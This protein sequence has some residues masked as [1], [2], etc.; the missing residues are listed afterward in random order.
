MN[1]HSTKTLERLLNQ[2]AGLDDRMRPSPWASLSH[3]QSIP[4]WAGVFN[5]LVVSR[6]A[7]EFVLHVVLAR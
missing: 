5:L 7:L 1:A 2:T 3:Y 4:T 6:L